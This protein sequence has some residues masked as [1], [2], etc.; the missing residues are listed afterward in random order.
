MFETKTARRVVIIVD[1]TL[2]DQLLEKVLELGA[3]GYN[4]IECTGK[5]QHAITGAHYFKNG[6]V[7][8]EVIASVEVVSSILDYIH[9]AQFQ[10]F[11][12]YALSAFADT[13]E[14]DMRDR[15]LSNDGEAIG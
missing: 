13:V 9:A 14:V 8:I 10:Q 3:K 11:G 15:S 2:K 6:L 7:R 4:Y 5:G 1:E 12:R